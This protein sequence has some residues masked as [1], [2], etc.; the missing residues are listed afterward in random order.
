M[1][2]YHTDD[3][4]RDEQSFL[5]R[6]L[7]SYIELEMGRPPN[8]KIEENILAMLRGKRPIDTVGM[9]TYIKWESAHQ[10]HN[11]LT[12][13]SNSGGAFNDLQA[14]LKVMPSNFPA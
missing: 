1:F 7:I 10:R 12:G 11:K 13:Q 3:F 4:S 9:E 6:W 5:D 14:F 2:D 8:R